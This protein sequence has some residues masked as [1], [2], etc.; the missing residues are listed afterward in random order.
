MKII[1]KLLIVIVLSCICIVGNFAQSNNFFEQGNAVYYADY[2][3]GRKT[4][5]GELYNKNELTASHKS[6]EYGTILKVTRL[7]NSKTVNVRVN[8]RGPFGEGLIVDLSRAAAAKIGLLRDGKTRVSIQVIGFSDQNPSNNTGSTYNAQRSAPSAYNTYNQ[9]IS[10][11]NSA[12]KNRALNNVSKVFTEKNNYNYSKF[13]Q[14]YYEKN[15]VA[16]PK[17]YGKEVLTARGGN[18]LNSNTLTGGFII[19]LA[20][21]TDFS[22]ANR[23]VDALKRNGLSN[24]FIL[25]KSIKG[26]TYNKVVVGPYN[27]RSAADGALTNLKSRYAVSGYVARQ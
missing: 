27:T 25:T 10:G 19:Q 15:E 4:A 11:V 8:D 1:S 7:D 2:L 18:N 20:S 21:F 6:L 16:T 14:P 13:D 5:S 22:N 26:K 9:R 24:V 23:Q 3:H 17:D 12:S